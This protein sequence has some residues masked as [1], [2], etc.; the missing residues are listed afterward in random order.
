[1]RAEVRWIEANDLPGWPDWSASGP[2]DEVQWFT[3][4]VGPVGGPGADLFQVAVATPLGLRERRTKGK[5]AG[6][7]V[8]RFEPRLVEQAIREFVA[9]SDAL[10]WDGVVDLLRARMRW[11]YEGYRAEPH[12]GL[13]HL[14][15]NN[16]SGAAA[17]NGG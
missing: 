7:V 11:E 10:T 8:D 15:K 14:T 4:G 1:M 17:D 16:D 5:F 12:Y 3:V 9:G 2:A 13:N 6:L